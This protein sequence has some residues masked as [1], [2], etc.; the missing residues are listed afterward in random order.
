MKIIKTPHYPVLENEI[1]Q[2]RIK[3]KDIAKM[4][5]IQQQTLSKKLQ[6]K[7]EFSLNE[8][9]LLHDRLFEDIS[10]ELLFSKKAK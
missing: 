1:S 5:D 3:K 6:G 7:I 4:L 2:R 10:I 8:A 9:I